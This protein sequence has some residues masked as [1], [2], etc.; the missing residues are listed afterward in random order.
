MPCHKK[1]GQ[2]RNRG[3]P[4]NNSYIVLMNPQISFL[5]AFLIIK[6]SFRK[7]NSGERINQLKSLLMHTMCMKL[8]LE[9]VIPC[10]SSCAWTIIP[11]PI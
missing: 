8:A 3:C 4:V 1:T 10:C 9:V 7:T 11:S 2:A 5:Q 6:K